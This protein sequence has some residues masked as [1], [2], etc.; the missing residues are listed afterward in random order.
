[1]KRSRTLIALLL[2][3]TLVGQ[4]WASVRPNTAA[5]TSMQ[6]M[7][8]SEMPCH[9]PQP[10]CPGCCDH[11]STCPDMLSCMVGAALIASP[12]VIAAAARPDL[13]SRRLVALHAAN[14]PPTVFRPPIVI[15]A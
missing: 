1:M 5:P 3:L 7:S 10:A 15:S 9:D 2:T 11:G 4:G 14:Q 12:V 8:S 6:A 13:V